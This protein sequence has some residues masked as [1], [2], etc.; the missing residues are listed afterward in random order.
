MF[1]AHR[2]QNEALAF[3]RKESLDVFNRIH[4][5]AQDILFV[6]QVHAAYPDIPILPNLRCG[7]WYTDPAIATDCPAYFKSTDGHFSNWSFN[8]R[9]PN[10]HLLPLVAAND[11][12]GMV[13][14][15]STRAGK[16]LPDALSKT[17][18]IW[19]AVV[20]RAILRRFPSKNAASAGLGNE[21]DTALY[22]PPGAVS[23]QEHAQIAARIDKWADALAASSYS[24]PDLPHPLRPMWLTPASGA[25]PVPPPGYIP[26]ICVSAS[27]VAADGAQ[28]REGGFAYIQGSGDDHELWGEGLTPTLFW[29]HRQTLLEADRAELPGMVARLVAHDADAVVRLQDSSKRAPTPITRVRSRILVG[30][31][32][33]LPGNW[34]QDTAYIVVTGL[35]TRDVVIPTGSLAVLQIEAWAG[36]KGQFQFLQDI[37]PRAID[38]A[39]AQLKAGRRVCAACD[40]GTDFSVGVA[41]AAMQLFFDDEGELCETDATNTNLNKDSIRTRLEWIIASHPAANPSRTTLKRVNEYL[42][43]AR[44]LRARPARPFPSQNSANPPSTSQSPT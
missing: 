5:I 30:A 32:S 36:K 39:R 10:L 37:L 26:V 42:L 14:V 38:F 11:G 43:S 19:C 21:W 8:L 7:A 24:L 20:N 9:R 16:R 3:L 35:A 25:L 12:A 29:R 33:D 31:V 6:N 41:L 40:T 18:P 44:E 13:I 15:D 23:A 34:Q 1:N 27:R 28:R 17:V 4:S 2:E 22:T